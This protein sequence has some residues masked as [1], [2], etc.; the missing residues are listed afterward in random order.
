[1]FFSH[2]GF[3]HVG[4]RNQ[5]TEKCDLFHVKSSKRCLW[6]I[7]GLLNLKVVRRQTSGFGT[8]NK[9]A[10]RVLRMLQYTLSKV[11]AIKNPPL[12]A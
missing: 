9:N 7:E 4:S 2:A 6:S 10:S 1:M 12:L 3:R 5:I 8:H 11:Q